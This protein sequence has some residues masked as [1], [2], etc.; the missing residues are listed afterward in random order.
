MLEKHIRKN[1]YFYS[2]R[3]HYNIS[4]CIAQINAIKTSFLQKYEAAQLFSKLMII[5]NISWAS[6]SHIRLNFRRIMLH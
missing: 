3:T 1:M 2:E 5:I 6:N 4:R